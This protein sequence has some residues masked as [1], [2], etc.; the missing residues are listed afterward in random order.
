MH[1]HSPEY[2]RAFELYLRKGVRPDGEVKAIGLV[3]RLVARYGPRLYAHL[4]RLAEE[5]MRAELTR[6]GSWSSAQMA[7]HFYL[8]GGRDVTLEEIGHMNAIV[9]HYEKYYFQ[10]FIDQI[11]KEAHERDDGHMVETFDQ[12]YDFSPIVWA[13][14]ESRMQGRFEGDIHTTHSQRRFI[15][16]KIHLRFSDTFT[17]PLDI[18]QILVGIIDFPHE[19]EVFLRDILG[20]ADETLI[21]EFHEEDIIDDIRRSSEFRGQAYQITGQW[22]V[23]MQSFL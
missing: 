13:H 3:G 9:A 6:V 5:R 11:L 2:K 17:D 14:G 22:T 4:V 7:I 21:E 8:G 10:R 15:S 1:P 18:R 23:D 20:F 16:G 19:V 12:G